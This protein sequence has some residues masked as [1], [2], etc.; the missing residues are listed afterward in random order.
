M[1]Q[2]VTSLGRRRQP[3]QSEPVTRDREP[4]PFCDEPLDSSE[5]DGVVTQ[6][7]LNLDCPGATGP[8]SMIIG[9]DPEDHPERDEIP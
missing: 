1:A 5:T 7:C 8:D 4:C 6:A 2:P 3:W 9:T